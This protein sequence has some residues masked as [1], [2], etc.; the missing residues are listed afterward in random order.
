MKVRTDNCS[1]PGYWKFFLWAFAFGWLYLITMFIR[2]IQRLVDLKNFFHYLLDVP[3][4]DIQTVTWQYVVQ[5]LMDLRD[6]NPATARP[7]RLSPENRRFIN[8]QSK[9]RMDAH[10]IANRLMRQDNYLIAMIN[11]D[12]LDCTIN[13][14]FLGKRQFFTKTVEWNLW[15]AVAQYAFDENNQIRQKFLYAKHRQELVQG[16]KRRFFLVGCFNLIISPFIV[17]YFLVTQFLQNFT[18]GLA[19][20]PSRLTLQL[21]ICRNIK[22]IP[23]D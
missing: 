11:K 22:R 19:N 16:L 3:D 5:K 7:E 14:P 12:I 20:F 1:L 4:K 8:G 2:D 10:D 15:L 9:Q 6:E 18:V 13:I 23:P 21:T 17:V